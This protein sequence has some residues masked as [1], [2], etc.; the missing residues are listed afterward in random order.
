MR[1]THIEKHVDFITL[2]FGGLINPVCW[3][4]ASQN[5]IAMITNVLILV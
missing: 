4:K 2:S 3:I 1:C 5:L